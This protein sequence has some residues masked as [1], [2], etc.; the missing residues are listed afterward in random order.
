MTGLRQSELV[1]LRWRDVDW[2]AQRIRVRNTFV[3]G[4]HSGRCGGASREDNGDEILTAAGNV[5]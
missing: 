5:Y 4:E 1:D 3:R 2:S